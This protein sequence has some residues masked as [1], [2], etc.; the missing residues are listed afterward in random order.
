MALVTGDTGTWE[1]AGVRTP[2]VEGP[3]MEIHN[4]TYYLFYLRRP[5]G[6]RTSVRG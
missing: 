4:G 2:T 6:P 5:R 3:F 1:T